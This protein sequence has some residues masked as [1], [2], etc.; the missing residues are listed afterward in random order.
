MGVGHSGYQVV[1]W[2]G[3]SGY[4]VVGWVGHSGYQVVG[5]VGH[6]GVS[7]GGVGGMGG[8]HGVSH[9]GVGGAHGDITWWGGWGGWGT[10]VSSGRVGG[11]HGH[12]RTPANTRSPNSRL[13][14]FLSP[15]PRFPSPILGAYLPLAFSFD[16]GIPKL[17]WHLVVESL[18]CSR[19]GLDVP[20]V[21]GPVQVGDETGAAGAVA[22]VLV[23]LSNGVH[24]HKVVIGAHCKEPSVW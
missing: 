10:W 22:D 21:R 12:K 23:P 11:A 20:A 4:Q 16:T 2:V 15:I 13:N 14:L 18:R 19:V 5:W 24:V 7:H 9:G 6:M 17:T 8:A 1:G 3:H